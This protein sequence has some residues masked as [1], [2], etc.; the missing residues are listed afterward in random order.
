MKAAIVVVDLLDRSAAHKREV[1]ESCLALYR[2][3]AP[4]PLL[5]VGAI[6]GVSLPLNLFR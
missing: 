5:R 2:K 1:H 6:P 4:V 3:N